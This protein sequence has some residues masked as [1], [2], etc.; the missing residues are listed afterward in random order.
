MDRFCLTEKTEEQC[1][2]T[3]RT[4]R[5]VVEFVIL[6]SPASDAPA[7]QRSL[8]R[9]VFAPQAS[10][11]STEYRLCHLE[12]PVAVLEWPS[13]AVLGRSGDRTACMGTVGS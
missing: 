3:K 11:M 9:Q 6:W 10:L 7:H 5:A 12:S 8:K 2:R 4:E 1:E 13:G